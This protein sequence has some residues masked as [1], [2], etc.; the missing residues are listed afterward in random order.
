MS[1]EPDDCTFCHRRPAV[2]VYREGEVVARWC[3]EC[4]QG[5]SWIRRGAAA[6]VTLR[7]PEEL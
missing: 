5:A 1:D 4:P 3:K 7:E 6:G 2:A